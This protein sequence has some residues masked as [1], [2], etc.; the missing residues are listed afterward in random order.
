MSDKKDINLRC[1]DFIHD[2]IEDIPVP[3]INKVSGKDWMSYG[4]NNDMPD[5]YKGAVDECSTLGSVVDM[6][7]TYV[8]GA[9][10]E[11]DQEIDNQGTMLSELLEKLVYDYIGI[12][13]AS[14]QILR[15]PYGEIA[16]LIYVDATCVRLNE[17]ETYVYYSKNWCKYNRDI[18][19]YDRWTKDNKSPNSIMYI[20][21]PK[22]RELYGQPVWNS[23]LRDALTMIEASKA[24]YNSILNQFSPN[25]LIS[26][27]AG[28]PDPETKDAMERSVLEKFS[29][30]NGAKIFMTWSDS[31]DTA[32]TLQSFSAEDYTEKYQAIMDTAKNNI[33]SAFRVSPQLVGIPNNTGFASEEY[34]DAYKLLYA[35]Q[36]RPI[37]DYFEKQFKKLNINFKFNEFKI[38][39]TKPGENNTPTLTKI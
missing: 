15:N 23:S 25:T 14:L 12:G 4:A 39:F 10:V 7:T 32:P 33:L 16:Q 36:I 28:I 30:S 9:G 38:D 34:E 22:S 24:N 31:A 27:N 5:V 35:T 20:K 17:D 6:I 37:Q 29:G 2:Y 26:F 1:I 8:A 13:A 19:K 11:G 21:N 3:I 18:R